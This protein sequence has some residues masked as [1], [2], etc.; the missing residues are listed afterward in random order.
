MSMCLTKF[1]ESTDM[2]CKVARNLSLYLIAFVIACGSVVLPE[3]IFVGK[4]EAAQGQIMRIKAGTRQSSRRVKIGLNKSLVLETPID[5]GDVLVSNPDIADAV[6]RS[7]RRVYLIGVKVGQTN[8]FLVDKA[9]RQIVSLEI[10]VSQDTG[11]LAHIINKLVRGARVNV[12][13]A[14]EAVV[15]T[16]IVPNP[17]ASKQASDIAKKFIG[18]D[19]K[20]LNYLSIEGR[21]Q[22][23]LKVVIAEV[24][25]E[26]VK[27]LGINLTGG[28]AGV[29]RFAA[30]S[31]INGAGSLISATDVLTS[32]TTFQFPFQPLLQG[33]SAA[34]QWGAG[35]Q[36]FGAQ[37]KALERTGM[38]KT[39]AEPTLTAISGETATFLAGGEFPVPVAQDDNKITVEFK[40]FGI[41]LA[42]SPLV[43][44]AGR[45]QLRIKTEVSELS[46]EGAIQLN[47]IILPAL[48]V[49]RAE[50]SL[51]LPSGGTMAMAGLIRDE[52]KKNIDGI[53]GLKNIP[54]LG[55]LFRS[56][57]FTSKQ[58]ELVIF[59]T[60]YI[61]RPTTAKKLARPDKNL[62]FASDG[63]SNLMGRINRIYDLTGSGSAHTS[64]YQ[65]RIGFIYE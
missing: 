41:A 35:N 8:V 16:G 4:A 46:N 54:I 29:G 28:A 61:V 25:R 44:S 64:P 5:V 48:K 57:E 51:E 58:S 26:V 36:V 33:G 27:Q 39:L 37:L 12:E 59:V 32:L 30:G 20:V 15:L 63:E 49:R 10:D 56:K 2:W 17:A 47:D 6:V 38:L 43:L 34:L 42:F 45:I 7:S 14:G 21:Q 22:V 11:G 55:A 3:S 60:P 23:H 19:K 65:G 31:G 9:G 62:S 52:T 40:E 53:P 13:G 18:D 50:T 24:Q 1:S